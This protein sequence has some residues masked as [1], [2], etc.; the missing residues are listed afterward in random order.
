MNHIL[1][2]GETCY[3]TT[4]AMLSNRPVESVI[5]ALLQ[6][7]PLR[8]WEQLMEIVPRVSQDEFD[9]I[10]RIIHRNAQ[11]ILPW[12]TPEALRVSYYQPRIG[13]SSSALNGRGTMSLR[14]PG[15]GHVV[16]FENGM[17]YDPAIQQPVPWKLWEMLHDM[18]GCK[19]VNLTVDPGSIKH[20]ETKE[21]E[22]TESEIY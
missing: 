11:S 9:Y 14:K 4:I 7:T 15:A 1:Q 12:I 20:G 22:E 18:T 6:H 19:V 3:P 5:R 13:L 10:S 17:I 16:A 21:A 2:F 8:T